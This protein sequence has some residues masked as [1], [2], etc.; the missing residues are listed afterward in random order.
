[1]PIR[2]LPDTLINQIAAGEVIERP[3][4]AVKE[5]VENAID[6]GSSRIEVIIRDG[7]ASLISVTDDGIG[8]NG[9][10]L[11]M[12][13]DRHA[14][15]K[16]PDDDLV[17]IQSL[18]FRGEALPSIGA[19]SRLTIT[20]RPRSN[21]AA[22]AAMILVDAGR[23]HPVAPAALS[24]GT[25]IEVRDL[26]YA[27][28]ARLKF[29]KSPRTE[30]QSVRDVIEHLAM[31][32]PDIH[33]RLVNDEREVLDLPAAKGDLFARRLDRLRQIM[34][35]EFAENALRI[36]AERAPFTLSG[37][38]SLPTLNRGTAQYQHFFV[39]GRPVRDKLI[40]GAVRGAYADFLAYGRHPM[41]CLFLDTPPD[42]VDV[43]VHPAKSEVRFQDSTLV[44]GLIVGGL[45]HALAEAGH[46]ASSTVAE[47]TLQSF[48][49]PQFTPAAQNNLWDGEYR[50]GAA[51]YK[52]LK[53]LEGAGYT[54]A[55]FGVQNAAAPDNLDMND[56]AAAPAARL[57]VVPDAPAQAAI[58]AH[59]LGAACAQIHENYIVAQTRDGLVLV[60]Q[61]AAHERIVYEK[62]KA[63]LEQGGIKRQALL[64]PEVVEL[65]RRAAEAL[66][67]RKDE[68]AELGLVI[69]SFG[70]GA[71]V[72]QE[73][74]A[75]L[76]KADVQKIVRDLAD[77]IASYGNAEPLREKLYEVCSTMACHGSVRSGR[78]LT[79]D[80]MNALL[81]QME[82]TPHA[83]QCNHGRPT[84][85]E[86][87][88]NDIEKLFG[89]R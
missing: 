40:I 15:S 80:E 50:Q 62:M 2:H 89:R 52:N 35:K 27:T 38:A 12:A 70:G 87:K 86:L 59:P 49:A 55:A 39:N 36:H 53:G 31:A 29:L 81:R 54:G 66:L 60:D 75:L 84:Y 17:H 72:V 25:K 63:A 3:A 61:H 57:H 76:G 43:N 4:A 41:L 37:Y 48:S 64:L 16:L 44:R 18:G 68:L 73:T 24:Q 77:D 20:S 85:V 5:L 23:K 74:P 19:V 82:Q 28:P 6:A 47:E 51:G 78:R 30:A 10:E 69:D 22:D 33:F 45:K 34:G 7:G 58:E 56:I 46:R 71:V 8:M 26:F 9:A 42:M 14:T 32:Y 13:V 67:E 79:A 1:M 88:L 65:D 11:A 83:G 21:P